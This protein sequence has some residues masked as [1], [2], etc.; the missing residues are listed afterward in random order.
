MTVLAKVVV[1]HWWCSDVVVV[2]VVRCVGR[3]LWC[4]DCR[5]GGDGF[6][7]GGICD[8][9]KRA[10]VKWMLCHGGIDIGGVVVRMVVIVGYFGYGCIVVV[11]MMVMTVV[12][13]GVVYRKILFI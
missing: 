2:M 6:C 7:K 10:I 11:L 4:G 1:G 9:H 5:G 3:V 8:C 12:R 13:E